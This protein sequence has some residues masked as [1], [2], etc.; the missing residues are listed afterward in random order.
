MVYGAALTGAPTFAIVPTFAAAGNRISPS[1]DLSSIT[2]VAYCAIGWQAT[3][4]ADTSVT[5]T[6]SID[7]GATYSAATNGECPT[8]V[9]AGGDLSTIT[10]FRIKVALATDDDTATPLVEGLGLLVQDTSGPALLYQLNTVPGITITDRSANSN[11][12]TM[13]FPTSQTGVN[14]TTGVL[15]STRSKVPLSQLLSVGDIVSPVTGAAASGNI[16]NQ[17]ETGFG[18]LP[19]QSMMQTMATGGELPLKFVWVVAIGLFSIALGVVAL[20]LTGSLMIS[21]VGMGAGLSVG[22]AVGAGLIPGWTIILFVIL[23]LALIVMRS[24]GALPL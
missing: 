8:G 2:E 3:T 22:A 21:G 9:T 12:G 5:V 14:A 7:G 23:A 24:R 10:D 4:P 11:T 18:S 17:T 20:H 19:F 13:S 15:E 6:T 1:I 16:F